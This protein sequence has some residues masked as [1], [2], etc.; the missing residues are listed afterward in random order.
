MAFPSKAEVD[1]ALAGLSQAVEGYSDAQDL[2]GHMARVE[3]IARAK[4]LIRSVVSAEM[5]PNYHGLNVGTGST[6]G[7]Q[8]CLVVYWYW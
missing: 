5:T 7:S 8:I 3:V 6:H 1:T 4:Q 2:N